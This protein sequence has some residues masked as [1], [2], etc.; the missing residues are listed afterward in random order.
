MKKNFYRI[1]N[2]LLSSLIALLGFGSCK[3]TK[4]A[5]KEKVDATTEASTLTDGK[6]VEGTSADDSLRMKPQPAPPRPDRVVVLYG[7]RP[8]QQPVKKEAPK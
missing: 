5:G 7:V 2:V 3:T 4:E 6:T 1:S 8:P